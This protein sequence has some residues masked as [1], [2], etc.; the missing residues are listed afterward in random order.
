MGGIEGIVS[1]HPRC[2][3]GKWA[4]VSTYADSG[5]WPLVWLSDQGHR[6]KA[7]Q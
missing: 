6:R 4:S 3:E 5:Q 1:G 2:V 7:W